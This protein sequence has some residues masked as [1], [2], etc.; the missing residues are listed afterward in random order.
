MSSVSDSEDEGGAGEDLEIDEDKDL[1]EEDLSYLLQLENKIK[2]MK[3]EWAKA[4]GD[5]AAFIESKIRDMQEFLTDAKQQLGITEDV[6]MMESAKYRKRGRG[7]VIDDE[8]GDEGESGDTGLFGRF[9][10][11]RKKNTSGN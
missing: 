11:M 3:V 2:L 8:D 7:E 9:K 6:D 4:Q 1:D 5:D 10:L